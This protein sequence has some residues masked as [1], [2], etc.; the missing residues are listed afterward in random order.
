MQ[1]CVMETMKRRLG[2]YSLHFTKRIARRAISTTTASWSA[3]PVAG[4][5]CM[6]REG[7]GGERI[8]AI[9]KVGV[10]LRPS[11]AL[12]ECPKKQA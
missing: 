9:S 12:Q 6:E 8:P 11:T 7:G 10:A 4:L 3:V 2:D 5:W 1:W